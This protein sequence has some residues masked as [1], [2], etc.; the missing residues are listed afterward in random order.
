[1]TDLRSAEVR[2]EYISRG[3]YNGIQSYII[4]KLEQCDTLDCIFINFSDEFSFFSYILIAGSFSCISRL[5]SASVFDLSF[6]IIEDD[7][8]IRFDIRNFSMEYFI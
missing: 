4:K 1:M 3:E 7:A 8:H 6:H 2:N 5:H